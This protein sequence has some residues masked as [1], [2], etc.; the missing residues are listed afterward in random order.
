MADH[1]IDDEAKS[2]KPI[3]ESLFD[4]IIDDEKWLNEKQKRVNDNIAIKHRMLIMMDEHPII[5]E[6][7]KLY[8]E[9]RK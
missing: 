1:D 5:E 3:K 8:E 9:I 7:F 2:P 6:W 4:S